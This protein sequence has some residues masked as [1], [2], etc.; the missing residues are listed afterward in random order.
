MVERSA[1]VLGNLSQTEQ[2][3]G[4]I[5][6]R[7]GL[8]RLVEL[9]DSGP[10]AKITEIAAKTLANLA[11]NANSRKSI[12]LAGGVPPLVNLL[13]QRPNAEVRNPPLHRT[14]CSHLC[15]RSCLAVAHHFAKVWR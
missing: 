5:R 13:T 10:S 11:T 1:A 12:R 9:L 14:A 3:F 4:A 8:Q 6:E 2:F 15:R 7:G